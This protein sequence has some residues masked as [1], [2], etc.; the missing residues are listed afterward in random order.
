MRIIIP[1]EIKENL[2][3]LEEVIIE[4]DDAS[5]PGRIIPYSLPFVHIEQFDFANL[6]DHQWQSCSYVKY[7][8]KYK[9]GREQVFDFESK[10]KTQYL[11]IFKI[12]GCEAA[13]SR[14]M[15]NWVECYSAAQ[16]KYTAR[17]YLNTDL[18]E[19]KTE[20]FK[21]AWEIH[22]D[23][24]GVLYLC[25]AAISCNGVVYSEVFSKRHHDIT[26]FGTNR[27]LAEDLFEQKLYEDMGLGRV[28][29]KTNMEYLP[30]RTLNVFAF[31][32]NNNFCHGLL[33]VATM[34]DVLRKAKEKIQNY[35]NYI[36]PQNS[37]TLI[38]KML[39]IV[40]V[41]FTKKRH[42]GKVNVTNTLNPGYVCDELV[43]PSV[44][45]F[46]RF[47]RP[48]SFDF[49]REVYQCV[50]KTK[51]TRKLYI[52]RE[53]HGRDFANR[54]QVEMLLERLGFETVYASKQIDLPELFSS[55]KVVVGA[56]GAAMA[57]CVFCSPGCVLVDLIPSVYVHPF[58]MSLAQSVYMEYIGIICKAT[59]T[60]NTDPNKKGPFMNTHMHVDIAQ[61]QSVLK[62][63]I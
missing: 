15:S 46:G 54:T 51:L 1:K 24:V 32:S 57:N 30:G 26:R 9:D 27:L 45:F 10:E 39:D 41:D 31:F 49:L 38:K 4:M 37:S 18:I 50:P 60:E 56:H 62:S 40:G 14:N 53:G 20:K 25:D 8:A 28:C 29:P 21:D 47:Y 42:I 17:Q 36:I 5:T 33:D 3:Q 59:V 23:S 43:T 6:A 61:L 7:I 63:V 44:N 58:F 48:G 34:L 12:D 52:S 35:D 55:A 2:N 16:V 11:A 13:E 19:S 22:F